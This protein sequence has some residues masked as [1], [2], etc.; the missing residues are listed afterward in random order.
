MFC[1][2]IY[3]IDKQSTKIFIADNDPFTLAIYEQYIRNLGYT[4]VDIILNNENKKDQYHGIIFMEYKTASKNEFELVQKIKNKNPDS[5]IVFIANKENILLAEN[6]L[7]YGAFDLVIKGQYFIT[8]MKEVLE[9]IRLSDKRSFQH[10]FQ[11]NKPETTLFLHPN[12]SINN[13]YW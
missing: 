7:K 6:G 2:L 11:S 4:D 10:P 8:S 3:M 12:G 1:K 13:I 5:Y 9:N